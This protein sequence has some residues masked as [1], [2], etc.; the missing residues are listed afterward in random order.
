[1][2]AIRYFRD[3]IVGRLALLS[4]AL[5]LCLI[6][7][8]QILINFAYRENLE[9]QLVQMMRETL[10][11]QAQSLHTT[12]KPYLTELYATAIDE[13]IY[14]LASPDRGAPTVR[15]IQLQN[16]FRERILSGRT[17]Q[18]LC[19]L[20]QNGDYVSYEKYDGRSDFWKDH[21]QPER[22]ALY[23]SALEKGRP[24]SLVNDEDIQRRRLVYVA[25]PLIGS[26]SNPR[27]ANQVVAA[28]ISLSFLGNA[29]KEMRTD[30]AQIYL[31]DSHRRIIMSDQAE[32]IG[33]V[34][35]E[36]A[37]PRRNVFEI[38]EPVNT[39]GWT[40]L[41]RID[42]DVF[43]ADMAGQSWISSI[44][45]IA[46]AFFTAAFCVLLAHRVLKPTRI[47][48]TAMNE[49]GGGNLAVRIKVEG[50]D[51]LWRSAVNFNKMI[52]QLEGYYETNKRY[53]QKIIDTERRQR[54]AELATL[55]SHINAHF[56]F[57]TLTAIGYQALEAGCREV[58]TS[59][60]SLANMMRY[61]FNGR[62]QNVRLYQEAAWV[63]QYLSIHK[64]RLGDKL[65]YE[66]AV[67]ED[68]SDWPMRKMMLQPFV[69]NAVLHGLNGTQ[70]VMILIKA[71]RV[72]DCLRIDIMDNGCGMTPETYHKI[73]AI[74]RNPQEA[75]EG[76]IGLSNVAERMY[77]FYGPG[78][79]I[80]LETEEGL[81]SAFHIKLPWPNEKQL[82]AGFLRQEEDENEVY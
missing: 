39:V 16:L 26:G 48:A 32:L 15:S 81:G 47:L 42:R 13:R 50:R 41:K 36:A 21:S 56:L 22:A 68:V 70:G 38:T 5:V 23:R 35:D 2:R 17:V 6:F 29:M 8:A 76:G 27:D 7:V 79:E 25:V 61:A 65:D 3:N 52:R 49:A 9:S 63:E 74:L 45:Y 11:L 80:T 19:V 20:S 71:G 14:D 54:S 58:S 46:L 10:A 59:I 31:I 53:Y 66:V 43:I 1:M 51:E 55:E 62:L 44:I 72:G 78:A 34:Y 18:A 33:R 77:S 12:L 60:K 73:D 75:A 82:A 28:S 37:A 67:E 40:L 69:E 24:A 30:S 64:E 4:F 57:N